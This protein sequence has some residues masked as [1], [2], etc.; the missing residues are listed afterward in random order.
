MKVLIVDDE[1]SVATAA[2]NTIKRLFGTDAVFLKAFNPDDA[3]EQMESH[4]P[5]DLIIISN[6]MNWPTHQGLGGTD[7]GANFVRALRAGMVQTSIVFYSS[8]NAQGQLLFDQGLVEGFAE[9]GVGNQ[10]EKLLQA[11][12][13]ALNLP[14]GN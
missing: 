1:P 9:K 10:P 6:Y 3:I 14:R 12:R 2:W 8:V 4:G 11:V 7:A 13:T 5:F